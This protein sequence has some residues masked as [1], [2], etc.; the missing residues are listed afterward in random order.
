MSITWSY[1]HCYILKQSHHHKII[2]MGKLCR[3]FDLSSF[4]MC[5]AFSLRLTLLRVMSPLKSYGSKVV[6]MFQSQEMLE[7][8]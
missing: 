6:R 4:T 5:H 8:G 3:F 1:I 7:F 2:V